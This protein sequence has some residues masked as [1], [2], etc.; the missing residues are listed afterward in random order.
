MGRSA[1]G[2]PAQYRFAALSASIDVADVRVDS[3]RGGLVRVSV[4]SR[5][6]DGTPSPEL[7]ADVSAIVTSDSVRA[8]CHTVLVVAAEIVII[9]V[10]G[11][12]YLTPTAPDA[13]FTALPGNLQAAFSVARGL[14][15]NVSQSWIIAQL[16][17]GG[18]QRVQL[19]APASQVQIAPNQCA[20]LGTI[21]LTLAGRDY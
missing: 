5:I 14:G 6:G 11:T 9:P 13:V 19:S 20:A 21:N 8:M 4:L 17:Q 16:Q 18:V 2:T 15:W 12:I 10:T 1:A 3:P 7:L